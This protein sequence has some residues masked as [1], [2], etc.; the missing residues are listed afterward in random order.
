MLDFGLC[1]ACVFEQRDNG[2]EVM[3]GEC[4]NLIPVPRMD[5]VRWEGD[6]APVRMSLS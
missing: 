5:A 4:T 3:F 2:M 6:C 1:P